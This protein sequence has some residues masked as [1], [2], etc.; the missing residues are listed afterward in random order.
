MVLVEDIF[1]NIK[2]Q[3]LIKIRIHT[4]CC[5]ST[6]FVIDEAP[7]KLYNPVTNEYLLWGMVSSVRLAEKLY[8]G[9]VSKTNTM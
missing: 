3:K 8:E 2:K 1:L 7:N 9:R 6:F 4:A 5:R